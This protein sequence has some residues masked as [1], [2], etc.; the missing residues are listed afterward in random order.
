MTQKKKTLR[1]LSLQHV[2]MFDTEN[3]SEAGFQ[4]GRLS[5]SPA[6]RIG[7]G[8]GFLESHSSLCLLH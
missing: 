8:Q 7:Q 5:F 2:L 3:Q 6:L 4:Y 1:A